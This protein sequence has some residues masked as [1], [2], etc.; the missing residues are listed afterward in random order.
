MGV[1]NVRADLL[2]HLWRDVLRPI[3]EL[4]PDAIVELRHD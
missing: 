1:G 4:R 2:D 3:A